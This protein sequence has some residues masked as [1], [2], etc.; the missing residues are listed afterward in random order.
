[1][2]VC[3]HSNHHCEKKPVTSDQ[4]THENKEVQ[5]L[6]S[7]KLHYVLYNVAMLFLQTDCIKHWPIQAE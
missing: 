4:Q 5:A 3:K 1:M 6:M 2:Q 7:E